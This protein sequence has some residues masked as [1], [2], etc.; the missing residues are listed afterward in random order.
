[1]NESPETI[2]PTQSEN[3]GELAK[4]VCKMQQ[5]N[6][7]AIT[8]STNPF[9]KSKYADLSSV[10]A[11]IRTPLTAN[12]LAIVQTTEPL[13]GGVIVVTTLMHESGQYITGRLAGEIVPDKKGQ[14]TP[15]GILSLITYLRRAGVSAIVGVCPEDDDGESLMN[16][17]QSPNPT[18]QTKKKSTDS[19]TKKPV[20]TK[21]DTTE[22]R[23]INYTMPEEDSVAYA[24]L[25]EYRPDVVILRKDK[26]RLKVGK[27]F[28]ETN[29][30]GTKMWSDIPKFGT[31]GFQMDTCVPC[32]VAAMLR[33][34]SVPFVEGK[35]NI[36]FTSDEEKD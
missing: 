1:M 17:T 12:G 9:F 30:N 16:R 36:K 5:T 28:V 22:H 14:K 19:S 11:A 25:K 8:D 32:L 10:W 33:K 31:P 27:Y 18:P 35:Y 26:T 24:H 13:E 6:L 20:V 23:G 3:I 29:G 4:A 34:E 7:F 15:Q 2:Q 21:P